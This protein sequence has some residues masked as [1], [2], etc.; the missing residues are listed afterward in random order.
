MNCFKRV[1]AIFL[2]A[3][4][5]CSAWAH[6]G[7]YYRPAPRVGVYVGVPFGPWYYP[8]VPYYYY[9]RVIA[10]PAAPPVYIEQASPPAAPAQGYW[11]YC[12]SAGA[13]YPYVKD[14]PGGWQKVPA[15]P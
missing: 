8:P 4:A 7:Y 2:L 5:A 6:P 14:C 3:V 13:Y 1:L 11:Y 15:Q 12:N 9:P 10:V